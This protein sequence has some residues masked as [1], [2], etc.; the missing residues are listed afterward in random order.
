MVLEKFT[1]S[2]KKKINDYKDEQYVVSG[3]KAKDTELYYKGITDKL[4][5]QETTQG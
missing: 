1:S 5:L 4:L 2:I 3:E